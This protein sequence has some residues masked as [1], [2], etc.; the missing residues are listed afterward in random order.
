MTV[1]VTDHKSRQSFGKTLQENNPD[2]SSAEWIA[3]APSQCDGSGNCTP[4]PLSDFG[5]VDFTNATATAN[6]HT[7]TISDSNWTAQPVALGANGSYDVS[8]GSSQNTRRRHALVAVLRRLV[9][10]SG[11]AA[12]RRWVLVVTDQ[13]IVRWLWRRRQRWQRLW[14][15]R[16][17]GR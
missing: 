2:T 5:T 10:F 8:Y 16:L 1:S 14:L 6:G 13:W 3:E 4:L 9:V 17:S 15:R 12:E 11:L 7:G